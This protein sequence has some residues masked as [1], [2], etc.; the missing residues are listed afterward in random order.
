MFQIQL[1]YTESG[2]KYTM[3]FDIVEK[4]VDKKVIDRIKTE[5]LKEIQ[6]L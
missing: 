6:K 4:Y 1:T 3:P 5:V 2:K